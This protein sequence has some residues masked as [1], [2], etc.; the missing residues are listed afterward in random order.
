MT[1]Y[2]YI[3]ASYQAAF[4]G[5]ASSEQKAT[6]KSIAKFMSSTETE[7]EKGVEK[8]LIMA[9]TT[10][11]DYLNFKEISQSEDT[12]GDSYMTWM[13]YVD[14][15]LRTEGTDAIKFLEEQNSDDLRFF[16]DLLDDSKGTDTD[17]LKNEFWMSH[18]LCTLDDTKCKEK[19]REYGISFI[20]VNCDV[21][22]QE[23]DAK[24][25]VQDKD[26]HWGR[27]IGNRAGNAFFVLDKYAFNPDSM[28]M[29]NIVPI[30]KKLICTGVETPITIYTV[31]DKNQINNLEARITNELHGI[32]NNVTVNALITGDTFHDRIIIANNIYVTIGGGFDALN[33]NIYADGTQK[34]RKNTTLHIYSNPAISS[35]DWL[36]NEY[37]VYI[38][39]I[40]KKYDALNQ[41]AIHTRQ[42]ALMPNRLV[43]PVTEL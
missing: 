25:L 24:F 35:K 1:R 22:Q 34:S 16:D 39:A 30:M 33:D 20:N 12:V 3:D 19:E 37:F 23:P 43:R 2:I 14:M 36:R 7:N 6:M 9:G 38:N 31:Y 4:I 8:K 11:K 27:L 40:S 32:N 5:N 18:C 29:A 21:T 26:Y 42:P 10:K 28:L 15:I 17:K 41:T 13:Q